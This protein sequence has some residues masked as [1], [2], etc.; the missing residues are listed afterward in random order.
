MTQ[1][2]N[3][4]TIGILTVTACLIFLVWC[5]ELSA[6]TAGVKATWPQFHGSDRVNISPDKG[7]LKEWPDA[8]P[9]LI[10][11]YDKCGAGFATVSIVGDTIFTSGDFGKVQ[12]VLALSL[13][14]IGRAHV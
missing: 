6:E 12:K 11:K 9:K 4:R 10:W 7:L 8:G 1:Q 3:K 2:A 13:D 5:S 14:E